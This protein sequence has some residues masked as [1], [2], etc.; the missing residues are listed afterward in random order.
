MLHLTLESLFSCVAVLSP[1]VPSQS[2]GVVVSAEDLSNKYKLQLDDRAV[3]ATALIEDVILSYTTTLDTTGSDS[4]A[5]LLSAYSRMVAKQETLILANEMHTKNYAKVINRGRTQFL[6]YLEAS[7]HACMNARTI[8]EVFTLYRDP[9]EN[10]VEISNFLSIILPTDASDY[11]N[12]YTSK[13]LESRKL[14]IKI[15]TGRHVQTCVSHSAA[16]TARSAAAWFWRA[17]NLHQPWAPIPG[18]V[19]RGTGCPFY[20]QGITQQLMNKQKQDLREGR[21]KVSAQLVYVAYSHC[22]T[23]VLHA[24]TACPDKYQ[25]RTACPRLTPVRIPVVTD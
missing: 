18:D 3:Q 8:D 5:R 17:V 2:L 14:I 4:R 21:G 24:R 22:Q 11:L 25:H 20:S 9:R 15:G 7:G 6:T 19:T 16:C 23:H 1:R 10:L 12:I 13:D